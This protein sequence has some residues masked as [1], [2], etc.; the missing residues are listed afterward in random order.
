LDQLVSA[1][2]V[3][4]AGFEPEEEGGIVFLR[5][6]AAG[7]KVYSVAALASRGLR[8]LDGTLLPALPG[9]E[10]AVLAQLVPDAAGLAGE[11]A[12]ALA[13]GVI[14]VGE[15]LA[16]APGAYSAALAAAQRLG[17][18]LVW[19]PRRAGERA[20]VEAGLLPGLLPGGR[21]VEPEAT[22]QDVNQIIAA[23]AEGQI[24]SLLVGGLEVS[25][26]PDPRA[27]VQ[28]LER[29]GV[30]A[31]QVRRDEVA[32]WAD[33][34]LP[35]APPQEKPGT[36]INWEGRVCP[37]PQVL[38]STALPDA[39]V[40]QV[41]ANQMGVEVQIGQ[42]SQVH[43]TL[44]EL[45]TPAQR[46]SAPNVE[47][48]PASPPLEPGEAWLS[49]WRQLVDDAAG[50]AEEPYLA[51]SAP[52]P[53]ARVAAATAEAAGLK[54][55]ELVTVS[56]AQGSITLPLQI[57][58]MAEGVVHLPAK[59]PG[60]WVLST[61]GGASGTRVKLAGASKAKESGQ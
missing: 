8:R 56:T 20:A 44:A 61:L 9:A 10:A 28:A 52:A 31:L 48:P 14:V 57:E 21:L 46:P 4:L 39:K 34:V 24:D 45:G 41:L 47:S 43:Q 32:P 15:R 27:A 12:A 16:T 40:L 30:V 22:G 55:G 37:F 7:T 59:S 58:D 36:Y 42:I 25:D 17:A 13:G 54:P 23:A 38:V 33:V 49:T 29:A 18:R 26:L 6:R 5:L 2:A 60:S 50:L 53:V 3:L 19:I 11:V 51:A 35:V 1:P